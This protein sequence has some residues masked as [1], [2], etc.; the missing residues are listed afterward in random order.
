MVEL[1][2]ESSLNAGAVGAQVTL[3]TSTDRH[4]RAV[5]ATSGYLSGDPIRLHFG[6]SPNSQI[7]SLEIRWSDGEITRPEGLETNQLLQVYQR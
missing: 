2:D 4:L 3:T 5:R 1:H 7:I 6:F